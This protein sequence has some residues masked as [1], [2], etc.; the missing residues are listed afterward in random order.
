MACLNLFNKFLRHIDY[1]ELNE[2]IFYAKESKASKILVPLLLWV[3]FHRSWLTGGTSNLHCSQISCLSFSLSMLRSHLQLTKQM[4]LV[5]SF[6]YFHSPPL[7]SNSKTKNSYP[8]SLVPS[9]SPPTSLPCG[10]YGFSSQPWVAPHH[11]DYNKLPNLVVKP[12]ISM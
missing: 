2:I 5:R 3:F 6:Q 11:K 12:L 7:D 4:I 8:Q 1:K 10:L 9:F